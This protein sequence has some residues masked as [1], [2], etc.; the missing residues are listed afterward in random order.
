MVQ[1]GKQQNGAVPEGEEVHMKSFM[2]LSVLAKEQTT[3]RKSL[4]STSQEETVSID[5][6]PRRMLD[7]AF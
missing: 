2:P 3:K 7:F 6:F 4:T 5:V 1:R